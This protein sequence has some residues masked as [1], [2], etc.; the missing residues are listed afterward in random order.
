MRPPKLLEFL[1][2]AS[3]KKAPHRWSWRRRGLFICYCSIICFSLADRLYCSIFFIFHWLSFCQDGEA[4]LTYRRCMHFLHRL[5]LFSWRMVKLVLYSSFSRVS[6]RLCHRS[7]QPDF[8][9]YVTHT[10]HFSYLEHFKIYYMVN[11]E[12]SFFSTYF[13]RRFAFC[14]YQV[15]A[16]TPFFWCFQPFQP[17]CYRYDPTPFV[18]FYAWSLM[19]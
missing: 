15:V 13:S 14:S 2:Q 1:S 9:F 7:H 19:A 6:V 16:A 10:L 4:S 8:I 3:Q 18:P 12:S 11:F 17:L 5:L